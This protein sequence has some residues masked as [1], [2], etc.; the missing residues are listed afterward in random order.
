ML[1]SGKIGVNSSS[2]ASSDQAEHFYRQGISAFIHVNCSCEIWNI[3]QYISLT[4]HIMGGNRSLVPIE[5]HISYL[6][7]LNTRGRPISPT[8]NLTA[9]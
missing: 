6:E 8:T 5:F 1:V 9:K 4:V 3:T 7:K 2:V